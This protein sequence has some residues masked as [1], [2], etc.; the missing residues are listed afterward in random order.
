MIEQAL[1]E[2]VHDQQIEVIGDDGSVRRVRKALKDGHV[3]RYPGSF[4]CAC[5]TR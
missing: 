2:L 1:L 3:L 5:S 4:R